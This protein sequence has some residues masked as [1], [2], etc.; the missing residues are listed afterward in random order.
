[1]HFKLLLIIMASILQWNCRGIKPNKPE[2]E[3]LIQQQHPV[4]ICLQETMLKPNET[5]SLKNYCTEYHN[6]P[7]NRAHG[8]V[9]I[10]VNPKYPYKK[11]PIQTHLQ[12]IAIRINLH[13]LITVCSIYLPPKDPIDINQLEN[14][15]AQLPG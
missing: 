4:C 6:T 7:G 2:L 1:M 10:M 15:I 12:A 11:L 3:L 9:A 13:K 14:L 8:G 5:F